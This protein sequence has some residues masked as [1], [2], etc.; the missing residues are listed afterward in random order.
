MLGSTL[1]FHVLALWT[2]FQQDT[3]DRSQRRSY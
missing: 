3:L 2:S 1:T